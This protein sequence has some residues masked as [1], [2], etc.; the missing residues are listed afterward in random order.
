MG[1]GNADN[2]QIPGLAQRL[3]QA[4]REAGLKQR[5]AARAIGVDPN[6]IWRYEND[7]LNPSNL[8]LLALAYTYGKSIGWFKGMIDEGPPKPPL[9]NE[10]ERRFLAAYRG[11]PEGSRKL[12]LT[13]METAAKYEI[14]PK[15]PDPQKNGEA[16]AETAPPP[17]RPN[18]QP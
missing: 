5:E 16:L 15:E 6:T 9:I 18:E 12:I 7:R 11:V 1:R 14:E 10:D 3:K 4:R 13:V 8:A 17:K 2:S